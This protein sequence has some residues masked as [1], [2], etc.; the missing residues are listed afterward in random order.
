MTVSDRVEGQSPFAPDA[1]SGGA[2]PERGGSAAARKARNFGQENLLLIVLVLAAVGGVYLLSR[3]KGPGKASAEIR[4]AE[5]QVDDA[6]ARLGV[7]KP[8]DGRADVKSLIE[9]FYGQATER[10]IPIRALARNPFVYRRPSGSIPMVVV[11]TAR[12]PT[13]AEVEAAQENQDALKTVQTLQLQAVLGGSTGSCA[14]ISNNLL[15]GGQQIQGWTVT[16]IEA[17]KVVLSYKQYVHE[18]K[19]PE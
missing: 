16:K 11:K 1:L 13:P 10:Q 3:W 19:L 7:P 14:I 6:L 15:T 5:L 4:T 9:G 8:T 17:R 12:P 2:E 18:L